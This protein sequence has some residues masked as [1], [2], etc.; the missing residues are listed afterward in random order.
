MVWLQ[1]PLAGQ[2][3]LDCLSPLVI[4]LSWPEKLRVSPHPLWGGSFVLK[5]QDVWENNP[6]DV[7]NSGDG[8]FVGDR[9]SKFGYEKP[10]VGI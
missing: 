6:Q 8:L 2:L 5:S 1:G 10:G 3:P 4:L 7:G 9:G